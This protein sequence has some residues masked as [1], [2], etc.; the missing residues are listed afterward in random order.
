VLIL[1]R[2]GN[3]VPP[4]ITGEI[5]A[6]GHGLATGYA[7]A[8]A[9]TATRFTPSPAGPPGARLYRTGDYGWHDH[10]GTIHFTGRRDDQVKVRGFRI[11]PGAIEQAV[12]AHPGVTQAAVLAHTDPS[13]DRRLIGYT[14]GRADGP[15]L[16][17]Y[18]AHTLPAHMIPGQWITLPALP[19]GPTGKVDRRALPAPAVNAQPV[20]RPLTVLEE[21]LVAWYSELLGMADVTPETDFFEVGGH[22]LLALRLAARITDVLGAEVPAAIVFDH[23]RLAD[24]AATLDTRGLYQT[25]I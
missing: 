24:L 12:L 19:L 17:A 10:H 9:L 23:P 5:A 3:P 22:S 21:L 16:A 4:G 13:G 20:S 6:G 15:A 11:E 18:L 25:Q 7:G 8:P 14:V 1:D 2:Y